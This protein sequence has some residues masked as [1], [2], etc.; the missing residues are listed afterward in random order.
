MN[1]VASLSSGIVP[2]DCAEAELAVRA[3]QAVA[4]ARIVEGFMVERGS[5]F[6][7]RLHLATFEVRR[8]ALDEEIRRGPPSAFV[9]SDARGSVSH[10]PHRVR[11]V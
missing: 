3:T 6:V 4:A 2:K 8:A 9:P 7:R 11:L 10:H 5:G 1:Q